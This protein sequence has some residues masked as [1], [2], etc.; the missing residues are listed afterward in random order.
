MFAEAVTPALYALERAGHLLDRIQKAGREDLLSAALRPDMLDCAAQIETVAGFALRATFPLTGRDWPRDIE[1]GDFPAGIDGLKARLDLAARQIV[2]LKREDFDAAETRM[3][4]HYAGDAGISQHGGV[5]LRL[6]ALPNLWFHLSMAYA[7]LRREGLAIGKA[8][9]DGWHAYG[10][11]AT[12]IAP[13]LADWTPPQAPKRE[14]LTGR[15]VALEPLREDHLDGLWQ[16]QTDPAIWR[17]M[18]TGPFADEVAF[19]EWLRAAAASADP[20]HF[21]VRMAD[22]RL[23]GTLSL[24]RIQPAAGSIEI[25]H[26]VFTPRLQRTIEASESIYLLMTWAFEAGYRRVE[27]K[28]DAANLASRRAAERFGFSYEGLFR[29]A[30]VVKGRNRDTAWFAAIDRD[31]P[32]LSAAYETWLAPDNFDAGGRQKTRLSELTSP[33]L[34]NRDPGL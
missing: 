30:M 1:T 17:H 15:T 9:F 14:I 32:A 12:F 20:L 34:V 13:P 8:D 2:T 24:M 31:W 21:A 3:V 7:I 6:F 18:A 23:G 19:A 5:Y 33:I 10:P 27:W 25:G 26:L 4:T 16:A 29:Q 28:C 11:D 22:G